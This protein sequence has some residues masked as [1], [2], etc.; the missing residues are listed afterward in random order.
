MAQDAKTLMAAQRSSLHSLCEPD[1]VSRTRPVC[2][3]VP[4]VTAPVSPRSSGFRHDPVTRG[5]NGG[6]DSLRPC[7]WG[8]PPNPQS[9]SSLTP[10]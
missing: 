6:F 2:L 5:V 8:L 4:T 9:D 3:D 10:L 7:E 1:P